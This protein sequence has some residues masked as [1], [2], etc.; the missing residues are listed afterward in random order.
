MQS[1]KDRAGKAGKNPFKIQKASV[2]APKGLEALFSTNKG[3]KISILCFA[4]QACTK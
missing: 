4:R 2:H 3:T 1:D